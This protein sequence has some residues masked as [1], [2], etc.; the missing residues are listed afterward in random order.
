MSEKCVGTLVTVFMKHPVGNKRSRGRRYQRLNV[1][2]IYSG[3][4]KWAHI[5]CWVQPPVLWE[6][7]GGGGNL[8]KDHIGMS[9]KL[10]TTDLAHYFLWPNFTRKKMLDL[11]PHTKY[12]TICGVDY[13]HYIMH[14]II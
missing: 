8:A 14:N 10:K 11:G 12:L 13:M 9:P 4:Y 7:G 1:R 2:A 5:H 6:V 3:R